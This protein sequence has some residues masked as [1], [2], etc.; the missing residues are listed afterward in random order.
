ML[1]TTSSGGVEP[2]LYF[3]IPVQSKQST[4]GIFMPKYKGDFNYD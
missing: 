3:G 4:Q 2:F 1:I